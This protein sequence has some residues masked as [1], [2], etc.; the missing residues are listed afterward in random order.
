MFSV[1]QR[2]AATSDPLAQFREEPSAEPE[3]PELAVVEHVCRS[4]DGAAETE[5]AEGHGAHG[6]LL[7]A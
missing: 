4:A 7:P 1:F 5:L 6:A 2:P 3:Q